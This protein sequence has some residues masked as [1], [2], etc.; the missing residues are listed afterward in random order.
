M[1]IVNMNKISLIGL[2]SD[3]DRIIESLMKMGVVEINNIEQRLSEQEWSELVVKDGDEVE[4]VQLEEEIASVKS[5]IEYLSKY[6]TRKKGLFEPKR[7]V[8]R[9]QYDQII[10]S[11]DTIW[12]TVNKISGYIEELSTLRSEEN[13]LSNLIASLE[14]WKALSIPVE[15]DS[16]KH[17]A[18]AIGVVPALVDADKMKQEL[19]TQVAES[20]FELINQDKDQSYLLVI[21]YYAHEEEAMGVLKQYGFTKVSF[22]ELEGT[23]EDNIFKAAN[24][25]KDIEKKREKVEKDI[26]ALASEKQNIEVLHDDLVVQKDR[27]HVLNRLV[28]TGKVFMLEGWVPE[29]VSGKVRGEIDGK[30]D[31]MVDIQKPDKEE[32]FPILLRNNSFVQPFE[33]ITELYSLPSSKGIDPN[34]FMAPFYFV[35]FGLMVSDAGYGLTLAAITGIILARYKLE[36]LAHKLVK[37][38][39]FGGISTFIWGALFGGWFGNIIQ[40]LTNQPDLD[41]SLWFDPLGDPM[42]LLIW[43]FIFGGIHLYVGMGLQ[44]YKFIKDG[45]VL[46][47]VFDVGSWYVLLTGLAFMIIGGSFGAAGKYM[48][49]AGAALLVLTQGRNENGIFKKLLTGILSLYNVTGYLSDVLSYSRLLALGLATGVIATVVNTMGSLF[50]FNVLGIIILTIV[51]IGGHA[52]N[53]LINALGAYVHASRLQ[54]VEFFGKF[55][56]GG[57]KAFEPLKINTKYIQVDDK[58]AN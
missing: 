9:S 4:V 17:T 34:V 58:E 11:K 47:A 56:E 2:E 15:A 12:N 6:D 57:G 50:G 41:L 39:F 52:F 49:I 51:F 32:E 48:A 20:Y 16:T 28:K 46:D 38:L 30:W 1:A 19:Y 22:K 45:K 35:F 37:M 31:C 55:Y 14:P 43:S 29:E 54:Y 33:M 53:I 40:I 3:K 18:I 8:S 26:A 21:Y 7:K 13:R 23:V 44:A 36:G 25:I 42:K 10:D 27:K 24:E 5:A